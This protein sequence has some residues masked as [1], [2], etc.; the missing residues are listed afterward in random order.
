MLNTHSFTFNPFAENMYLVWD[1]SNACVII[2]PGCYERHEREELDN[3]ISKNNLKVELILNTHCHIDHILGNAYLKQKYEV[4]LMY[5]EAELENIQAA[6]TYS[7]LFGINPDP[8]PEADEFVVA[9]KD[10]KWGD[11]NIFK[12]LFTPGHSAGHMSF[13]HEADK[14]LFSGDVLFQNSIGRTDLP[15]G[16]M[17]TLMTSIK[18]VLLPLGDDVRVFPGHMGETTLGHERKNNQFIL[19]YA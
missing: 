9:G 2:D 5:P 12:V 1:A 4:P 19:H 17:K 3:F 6:L 15:G 7:S 8:S 11:G 18:E 10:I 13:F 16:D 14:L